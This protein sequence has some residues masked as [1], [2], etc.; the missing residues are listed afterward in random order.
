MTINPIIIKEEPLDDIDDDAGL[1]DNFPNVVISHVKSDFDGPPTCQI[2]HKV[3]ATPHSLRLYRTRTHNSAPV[4]TP[5]KICGKPE[6]VSEGRKRHH[7]TTHLGRAELIE[8]GITHYVCCFCED[9]F[10]HRLSLEAHSH[11]HTRVNKSV[12]NFFQN[13]TNFKKNLKLKLFKFT[14]FASSSAPISAPPA[15]NLTLIPPAS[16]STS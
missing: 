15:R 5:C 9:V 12:I 7:E 3:F 6:F 2:C 1:D 4:S 8:K 14:L 11:K 10:L 16:K 13:Y